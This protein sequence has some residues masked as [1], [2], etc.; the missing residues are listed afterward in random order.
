MKK[1]DGVKEKKLIVQRRREAVKVRYVN[2]RIMRGISFLLK[3]EV[4]ISFRREMKI[5]RK[6]AN[7]TRADIKRIISIVY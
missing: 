3:D 7:V 6:I 1:S 2:P 4:R 5:V